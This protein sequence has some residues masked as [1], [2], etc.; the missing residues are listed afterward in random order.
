MLF[1]LPIFCAFLICESEA[2]DGD[3]GGGG[4]GT[5]LVVVVDKANTV[6]L[7]ANGCCS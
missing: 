7:G 5:S 3:G 6:N 2:S 1:S 4:G